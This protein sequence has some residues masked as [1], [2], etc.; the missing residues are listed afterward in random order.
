[1]V[2]MVL[3][4]ALLS[5]ILAVTLFS[6]SHGSMLSILC[7]PLVF[8]GTLRFTAVLATADLVLFVAAWVL[9]VSSTDILLTILHTNLATWFFVKG[10]LVPH[11]NSHS[12]VLSKGHLA[13]I[14]VLLSWITVFLA[15]SLLLRS[16]PGVRTLSWSYLYALFALS[17]PKGSKRT[18]PVQA[19]PAATIGRTLFSV[20]LFFAVLELG[21]RI[22][23]DA[24][25]RHLDFFEAHQELI[26]AL[27]PNGIGSQYNPAEDMV[28]PITISAQGFRDRTLGPKRQDE[29]RILILGDSFTFGPHQPWEKSTPQF[30][31][32]MLFHEA[33]THKVTV[34]NGGVSGYGP[35]Q[36]HQTLLERGLD[37]EPDLVILQLLPS[38]DI[39]DSLRKV[40]KVPHAYSP[41]I[42]RRWRSLQYRTDWRVRLEDWSR[43]HVRAYYALTQVTKM[44]EWLMGLLSDL[45]FFTEP[46]DLELLDVPPTE[47]RPPTEE[48]SLRLW[49]PLLVEGWNLFEEDVRA[50]RDDCNRHAIDFLAYS[51]PSLT[52]VRDEE[53]R[54]YNAQAGKEVYERLKETRLVHDF[55]ERSGIPYVDITTPLMD[56]PDPEPLIQAFDGHFTAAG[57]EFVARLVRDFLVE[58]YFPKKRL[59]LLR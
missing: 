23:F 35:W 47:K 58:N 45:R 10:R 37:L 13:K 27:R 8:L 21:T 24:P 39:T 25:Q 33:L 44:D 55:F 38:N 41:H 34:I 32:K 53:W 26:F 17:L 4:K 3:V 43:N 12:W 57:N 6:L 1:M 42:L 7:L 15:L 59:L 9:S 46:V 29:F 50:I 30:L 54:R 18:S 56:V 52:T 40:G 31:E 14:R 2:Q 48:L 11:D 5:F 20:V 49:Y 19:S 16:V 22:V 28:V 51:I 36:E